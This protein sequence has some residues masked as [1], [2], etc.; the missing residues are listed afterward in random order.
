MEHGFYISQKISLETVLAVNRGLLK[1]IF[2][3][4]FEH[5]RSTNRAEYTL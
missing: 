2:V 4:H 3:L 5:C 1:A